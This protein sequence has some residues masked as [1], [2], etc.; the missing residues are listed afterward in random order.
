MGWE[1]RRCMQFLQKQLFDEITGLQKNRVD[2]AILLK[3]F[4]R[5]A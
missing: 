1:Q 4:E 2:P 5:V 3:Q